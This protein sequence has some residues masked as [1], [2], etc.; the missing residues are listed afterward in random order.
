MIL[1]SCIDNHG[2]RAERDDRKKTNLSKENKEREKKYRCVVKYEPTSERGSDP[3]NREYLSE[4]VGRP[5][6]EIESRIQL[7]YPSIVS[8]W[9]PSKPSI[10]VNDR[11]Q[12][13]AI[14]KTDQVER[15]TS[16]EPFNLALVE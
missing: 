11:G 5:T 7:V 10:N 15:R 12:W 6:H 2:Q 8:P 16:L 1:H 3:Q 9:Q 4:S 13:R 14:T